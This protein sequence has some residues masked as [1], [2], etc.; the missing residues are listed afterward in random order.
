ML[1]VKLLKQGL[2]VPEKTLCSYDPKLVIRYHS[3]I[4]LGNLSIKS[5]VKIGAYTYFESGRIG[6][7]EEI[8]NYCSVAPNVS[9][10]N[11]NHPTDYLTTHPI[12]F[13]AAGV[14]NFDE[15]VRSYKGGVPR[16]K[17]V[18]SRPPVIGNDV[19][20]G[21]NVTILRGVK[22]GDGAVIGAGSIV[23]SD[24]P[25]FAIVVGTPARV[26]RYRFDNKTI[27]EL[28]KLQWWNYDIAQV[29]AIPFDDI[30]LAIVKIKN[31]LKNKEMPS[32][33]SKRPL[34]RVKI[35]E[36]ND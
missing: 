13:N 20:I 15:A 1:N 34:K 28:Q 9:I 25:D 6:S 22:I 5:N 11:G 33:E 10:G 2:R 27:S 7:L 19:W 14:F 35:R 17:E 16:T 29:D 24:V 36:I 30:D 4:S 31:M 23:T 12:A 26:V 18:I 32:I 3:P 21:S 8:G